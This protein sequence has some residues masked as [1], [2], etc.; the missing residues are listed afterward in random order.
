MAISLYDALIPGFRQIVGTAAALVDKAEAHCAAQNLPH[1]DLVQARLIPDMLPFAYQIKSV[2]DHSMG[3]IEGVRKGVYSPSLATPP[4]NFADLKN[5]MTK[6]EASL[7]G[8]EASEV[9][10]FEGRDMRFEFN[11][12]RIDFTAENF[13]FSF[14]QPNFYFHA[15]TA[16][17]VLRAKGVKLGKTMFLGTMRTKG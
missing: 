6:T 10:G 5:L 16:Y 9:N 1:D 3:A 11:D 2:A 15:T 8:L 14:A 12:Y 4:D 7:S 13:L 17:D